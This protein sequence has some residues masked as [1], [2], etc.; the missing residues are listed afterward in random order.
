MVRVFYLRIENLNKHVIQRLYCGLC[1]Q[2]VR[3]KISKVEMKGSL[4][5]DVNLNIELYENF[6]SDEEAS[7]LYNIIVNTSAVDDGT[8]IKSG[9]RVNFTFGD[10]GV[11]YD[12][13]F[14]NRT[15][16]R[17]ARPW[18]DCPLLK[19]YRDRLHKFTGSNTGY[20]YVVVQYYPSGKTQIKPHRDKEMAQGTDICGISI[21]STR[22]LLMI[23]TYYPISKGSTELYITLNSG[24]LY[25]L[26]P[27]TNESKGWMHSI[28]PSD[29]LEGRVSLTYRYIDL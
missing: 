22:D 10:D 6:L 17:I 29:T 9:R 3:D 5:E 24:S 15:I 18:S 25:I 16:R 7:N 28:P 26:N 27:P 2:K 11:Y 14:G 8:K 23:P 13:T 21:G 20:N 4:Y 1:Y 19:K 12:V